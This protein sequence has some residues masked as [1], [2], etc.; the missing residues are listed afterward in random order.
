MASPV[1]QHFD[2]FL[3][4][5]SRDKLAIERVAEKLKRVGLEAL[6]RQMVP[7]AGRPVAG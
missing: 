6:A 7:H 2:V 4:H 1:D 5:N 3:S